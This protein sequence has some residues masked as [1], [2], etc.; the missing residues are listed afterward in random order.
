M[1][2]FFIFFFPLLIFAQQKI[3][4][5]YIDAEYDKAETFRKEGKYNEYVK[6]NLILLKESRKT[7]YSKGIALGYLHLAGSYSYAKDYKKGLEYLKLARNEEYADNNPE[8]QILIKRYLGFN[9]YNM[10][11][12]QEAITAFKDVIS[13]S[14]ELPADTSKYFKSAAYIEMGIVYKDQN[15]L[16][17]SGLSL[18][19]GLTILR[20]RK[21]TSESKVT[22]MIYSL[23]LIEIDVYEN[24]IDSAEIKLKSLEANATKILGNYNFQLYKVKGLIHEHKKEYDS[25][26]SYYQQAIP[27]AKNVKNVTQIQWLYNA[28]SNVYQKTGDKDSAE[29]YFQKYTTIKDSLANAKQPAIENTVKELV[30]QKENEIKTKS[31]FLVYI[32][33]IGAFGIILFILLAIKRIRRKNKILDV[34]EQET[35]ALNKKLNLAFE[36]VVRL[37]KN[38]DPEFLTRFQ[39]VYPNFF[40]KLLQIEPQLQNSELKFCALLFLNFSSKDIATYTFVQPQSIQTRKNRLR[41]KLNIPSEED[42]YIWM[43][44]ISSQ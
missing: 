27:L 35:Q 19:K 17:S 7:N 36:E 6:K 10:G 32:I 41:K 18:R 31:K 44:N 15:K 28:I 1:M 21:I 25:A 42:I 2:K 30:N 4:P 9:Y 37:A 43:K 38:N 34:K 13:L 22:L 26:I 39:E 5:Q 40:P 14:D 23:V 16:D 29:K 20:N 12:Y 24:K 8:F 11:L 33:W 3:T